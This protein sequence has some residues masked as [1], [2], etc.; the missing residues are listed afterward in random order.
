[1]RRSFE[2]SDHVLKSE[3]VAEAARYV[4]GPHKWDFSIV[5]YGDG[6]YSEHMHSR[7]GFVGDF[8]IRADGR[9]GFFF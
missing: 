1:M 4:H 3:V 2:I 6:T 8:D 5:I 9:G 7:T